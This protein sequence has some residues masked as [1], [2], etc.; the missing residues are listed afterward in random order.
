MRSEAW[1][2]I[3]SCSRIFL[4]RSFFVHSFE[5][6]VPFRAP[7]PARNETKM[8]ARPQTAPRAMASSSDGASIV[9]ADAP[10]T[11]PSTES[12]TAVVLASRARA[13]NVAITRSFAA[14]AGASTSAVARELCRAVGPTAEF[15]SYAARV[16]WLRKARRRRGPLVAA[17]VCAGEIVRRQRF[18]D[19]SARARPGRSGKLERWSLRAVGAIARGLA[20]SKPLPTI[21]GRVALLVAAAAPYKC[22]VRKFAKLAARVC[23]IPVVRVKLQRHARRLG[24]LLAKN[25][26][27][28]EV[29]SYRMAL[30]E[31]WEVLEET[32]PRD[33]LYA[34]R[35][36][37]GQLSTIARFTGAKNRRRRRRGRASSSRA[38]SDAEGESDEE[39]E[40]ERAHIE[41][42]YIGNSRHV[43]LRPVGWVKGGMNRLQRLPAVV[44][45]SVVATDTGY[46]SAL[47]IP[48]EYEIHALKNKLSPMARVKFTDTQLAAFLLQWKNAT[49]AAQ[50]IERSMQWRKRYEFLNEA[51]LKQFS[52]VVFIHGPKQSWSGGYQLVLRLRAAMDAVG[53]EGLDEVVSAVM[54][55]AEHEWTRLKQS[56]GVMRG[57]LVALVDCSGIDLTSLPI[58]LVATTLVTLDANYPQLA[59]EVHC[60]NIWWLM[61]RALQ[62]L[63]EVVS[64][65]TKERISIYQADDDG[66]EKLHEKFSPHIL[67]R[68]IVGGKCHCLKCKNEPYVAR[69]PRRALAGSW[70]GLT[71]QQMS[72]SQRRQYLRHLVVYTTAL[73]VF[74]PMFYFRMT[75][76]PIM[77]TTFAMIRRSGFRERAFVASL[78]V[79]LVMIFFTW[80]F[81]TTTGL[82]EDYLPWIMRDDH[83]AMLELVD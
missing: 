71:W 31:A 9:V 47:L 19:W 38:G 43:L 73:V 29:S 51:K 25:K 34:M 20:S 62:I 27:K 1:V 8:S 44:Y 64:S 46:G 74:Y 59:C 37:E 55:H 24:K 13:K 54:T 22:F 30:N 83:G 63:L 5:R 67:P 23:K 48:R 4:F 50:A 26:V 21:T 28:N 40:D 80:Q 33:V 11:I 79:S 70:R 6:A 82:L 12:A 2:S 45:D 32:L 65:D 78:V 69:P 66:I 75:L 10:A 57:R 36:A 49:V 56:N 68:C 15:A 35:H 18:A 61:R 39:S 60:I 81:I 58:S 72:S 53:M 42:E 3:V 16:V 76:H 14:L 77:V 17:C 52:N 7:A 41:R